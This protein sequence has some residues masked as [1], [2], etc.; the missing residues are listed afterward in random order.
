MFPDGSLSFSK[1]RTKVLAFFRGKAEDREMGVTDF[2]HSF[3]RGKHFPLR[4]K[5]SM[6]E[7][8]RRKDPVSGPRDTAF[9]SLFSL[10]LFGGLSYNA[11][12]DK[13]YEK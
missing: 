5:G 2:C 13:N 12:Y 3:A 4:K 10:P 8:K 9:H 6:R 7:R 11:I 1:V